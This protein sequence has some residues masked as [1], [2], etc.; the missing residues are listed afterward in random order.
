MAI[1]RA[2]QVRQMLRRGSN[3]NNEKGLLR[4]E[5][6]TLV[7]VTIEI[8]EEQSSIKKYQKKQLSLEKIL[9]IHKKLKKLLPKKQFL[10]NF[11]ALL[12]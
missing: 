5:R 6:E 12:D 1:T 7:M 2:Q 11:L 9:E 10:I 3:P 4:K 8:E